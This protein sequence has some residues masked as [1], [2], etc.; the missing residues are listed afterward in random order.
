M[1][2]LFLLEVRFS[3]AI[4]FVYQ[5]IT[6]YE[7]TTYDPPFVAGIV[8]SPWCSIDP[9]FNGRWISCGTGDE[10]GCTYLDDQTGILS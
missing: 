6:F 2:I 9:V 10:Y 5:G 3:C 4:P 1:C 8:D 7:C